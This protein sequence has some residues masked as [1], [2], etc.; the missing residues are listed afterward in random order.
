V[1]SSDQVG[2][3]RWEGLCTERVILNEGGW[4]RKRIGAEELGK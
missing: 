2:S 3:D 1:G 4:Q